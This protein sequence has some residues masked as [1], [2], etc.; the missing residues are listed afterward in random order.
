MGG[1]LSGI[2]VL[3]L[4]M[5]VSGPM[6]A[7]MLADAGAR[8]IKIERIGGE[9][10]TEWDSVVHGLSSAYVWNA[11]NKESVALNLKDSR[12]REIAG[13][14]AARAD[15]IIESFSPGT[16]ARMGLGYDDVSRSNPRVVYCHISGYGQRGPYR[17]QKAFDLLVQGEGGV[18]SMNGTPGEICKVPIS[19]ADISAAMY[20]NQAILLALIQR[21]R[22]GPGQEIDISMLH[23]LVSWLGYYPYF[24]WFRGETPERIGARHHLLTPYGPYQCSDEKFVNVAVLSQSAWRLFC[25]QALSHPSWVDDPRFLNNELRVRHRDEL[26]AMIAETIRTRSQRYWLQRL[27]EL[28]IPCGQVRDL[29]ETLNHPQLRELGAFVEAPSLRGPIP[30]IANPI[31]LSGERMRY[32]G[33]PVSGQHTRTVLREIGKSD[34]EI[35]ELIS[36]GVASEPGHETIDSV[37]TRIQL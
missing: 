12:G 3:D 2:F 30:A 23:C 31:C 17:D 5:S 15:V 22:T 9:L 33:V 25:E 19:I 1:I 14:L 11:R 28:D 16:I 7:A 34:A 36:Q 21:D 37:N 4:S 27:A 18:L 35:S 24:Y 13:T 10:T 29:A 8:V 26:E 32:D 20:A 6:A